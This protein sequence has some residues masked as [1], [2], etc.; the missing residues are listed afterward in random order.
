[1]RVKLDENLPAA[2]VE[3]IGAMGHDVDTVA[4]EKCTGLPDD[5]VVQAARAAQRVLFTLDK[6]IGDVRRHPP[7]RHGGVV[8]I[9]LRRRGPGS[10]RKAVLDALPRVERLAAGG[11]LVVVTET[12]VRVRR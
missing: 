9:R 6:G 11:R 1:M 2:L 4:A 7:G 5:E 3:E 10:A 12:T 8:L